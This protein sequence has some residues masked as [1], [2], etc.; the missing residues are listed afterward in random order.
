METLESPLSN[1]QLELLKAFSHQLDEKDLVELRGM[2]AS[3]FAKKAIESAN[4]VWDKEGW[5][6]EKVDELLNKKLRTPYNK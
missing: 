2:L 6:K 4:E 5:D 1:L 3:F